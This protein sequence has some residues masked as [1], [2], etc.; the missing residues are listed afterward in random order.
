MTFGWAPY[1]TGADSP[2][3]GGNAAPQPPGPQE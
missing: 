3:R 1:R 2:T